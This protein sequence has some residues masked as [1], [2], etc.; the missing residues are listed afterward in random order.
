LAAPP[1]RRARRRGYSVEEIDRNDYVDDIHRIN[2]SLAERQGRP[3]DPAYA[4]KIERYFAIDSF[5]YFG[6][7]DRD[8]RLAAYCDSCTT[9]TWGPNPACGNLKRSWA[10]SPMSST[11][12]SIEGPTC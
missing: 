1:P 11:T 6:V 3:M 9:P 12:P 2:T 5:R 10:S 7:L 8:R 4:D